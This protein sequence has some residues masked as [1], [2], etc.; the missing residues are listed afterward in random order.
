M[1]M[2]L[3]NKSKESGRYRPSHK[4]DAAMFMH[5]C[6]GSIEVR[7][8]SQYLPVF[9]NHGIQIMIQDETL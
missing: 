8:I 5:C 4:I 9:L 3:V 2:M 7:D 6:E 1:R